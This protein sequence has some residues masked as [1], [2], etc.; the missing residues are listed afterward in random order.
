M[1]DV[2]STCSTSVYR[3]IKCVWVHVVLLDMIR[4]TIRGF[5]VLPDLTHITTEYSLEK[6]LVN[7][8]LNIQGWMQLQINEASEVGAD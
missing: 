4:I 8:Q 5:V 1:W 2:I 3:P 6:G 7:E